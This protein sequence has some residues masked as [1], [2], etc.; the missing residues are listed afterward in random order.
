MKR[1]ISAA[2]LFVAVVSMSY[3]QSKDFRLGRWIEIQNA[4]IKEL[5]KSYVDTLPITKME[6]ASIDAMLSQ[7]DPYTVYVPEDEVEDF[8]LMIGGIYGG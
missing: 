8:S 6:R 3:A 2:F 5:D 1:W 4:I 7:L